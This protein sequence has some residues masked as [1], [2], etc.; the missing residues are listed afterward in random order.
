LKNGTTVSSAKIGL[1]QMG[2]AAHGAYAISEYGKV[3]ATLVCNTLYW[4]PGT[5]CLLTDNFKQFIPRRIFDRTKGDEII[6][7]IW[8]GLEFLTRF[9]L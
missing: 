3:Y 9:P 5:A 8:K 7:E 6:T 1:R 2:D 4:K